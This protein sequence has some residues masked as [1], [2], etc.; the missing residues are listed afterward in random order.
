MTTD[1]LTQFSSD[2]KT[3]VFEMIESL[4]KNKTWT[5]N[6]ALEYI[7]CM[8]TGT[9]SEQNAIDYYNN[10]KNRNN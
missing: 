3:K 4:T 6:T 7:K 8:R 1:K 2:T 9:I 5:D 10:W